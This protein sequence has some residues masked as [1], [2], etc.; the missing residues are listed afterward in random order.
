MKFNDYFTKGLAA[1]G[2]CLAVA[3]AVYVTQS[4]TPVWALLIM[5]L[6]W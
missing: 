2:I 1:V 3:V 5:L 6:I 4:A